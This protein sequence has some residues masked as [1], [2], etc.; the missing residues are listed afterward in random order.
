MPRIKSFTPEQSE[1]VLRA[2]RL[3]V[4]KYPSQVD[5]ARA[6]GIS[7]QSVCGALK[8][9]G[10]GYPIAKAVA[11]LLGTSVEE[12]LGPGAIVA[13]MVAD[14]SGWVYEGVEASFDSKRH[15]LRDAETVLV[16]MR[17]APEEVHMKDRTYEATA[18]VWLDTAAEYRKAGKPLTTMILLLESS[19]LEVLR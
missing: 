18:L 3:L 8:G 6:L 17:G 2:I 7:A 10:V 15:T 1:R 5:L 13:P 4:T 16:L 14:R 19:G 9:R 12:L 11:G